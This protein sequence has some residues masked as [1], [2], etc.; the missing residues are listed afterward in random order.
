MS[1]PMA[2]KIRRVAGRG[3]FFGSSQGNPATPVG[4]RPR[5]ADTLRIERSAD[6]TVATVVLTAATMA[7]AFFAECEQAFTELGRD[8]TLRAVVVQ[9]EGK[10]FSYG[11]DLPAAFRAWSTQ[12]AGQGAVARLQLLALVREL[13][14]AF[15]AIAAC[16]V[17]VIA[18]VHGW[19]IGGGLDLVSACDIRLASADATFSLRETKV[20]M[21]ADLGSL[22][23]LPRIIGHGHVREL[24]FTGK[25]IPAARAAAIGL[26]NDVLPDRAAV[27]AA[28]A[29]LAAEIAA[30]PPLVVRG[31]KE[32]LEHG[33]GKSVA[34]GLEYVAAWNA[35]FLATEDLGEAAAAFLQKR[36]PVFKGR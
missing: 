20:A 1:F 26:V 35:A 9:S 32:V 11:L 27:H 13:Q 2:T 36:P 19:C 33:E 12:L 4:Y 18:A 25:D 15:T 30:N 17:P 29:A 34:D 6:G 3:N 23:R 24:A 16:P 28:A 10:H 5:M 31:V 8:S 14:R 7:P 21:V 22:Q